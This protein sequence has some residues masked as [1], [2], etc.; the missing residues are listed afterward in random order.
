MSKAYL[1][2]NGSPVDDGRGVAMPPGTPAK[3]DWI[4]ERPIA[5]AKWD[6]I[7]AEL[8]EIPGL[9]STLDGDA[10]SLYCDAWQTFHDA[11]ALIVQHGMIAHSEKG[12]CYQFPAVGIANKAREQLVKIGSMFGLNPPAREGM[13]ASGQ[14]ADDE[15]ADLIR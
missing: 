15:L 1:K 11:Q 10:L 14:T 6:E 13:V 7:V 5:S 8:Q 12:G 4:A 2:I 9:L 3:P